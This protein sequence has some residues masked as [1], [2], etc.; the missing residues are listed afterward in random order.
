MPTES[1]NTVD[2]GHHI[3]YVGV[4][5]GLSTASIWN[6]GENRRVACKEIGLSYVWAGTHDRWMDRSKRLV[7]SL[8][9]IYTP[10]IYH[11]FPGLSRPICW[12]QK[13]ATHPL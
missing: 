13:L 10:Y 5:M 7:N 8:L 2:Y 6:R 3:G 11:V 4:S 9:W 12:P 1:A